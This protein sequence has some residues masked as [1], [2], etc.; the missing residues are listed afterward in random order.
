[1]NSSNVINSLSNKHFVFLVNNY[2]VYGGAERQAFILATYLKSKLNCKVSF[3]SYEPEGIFKNMLLEQNFST[4][5]VPFKHKAKIFHKIKDYI[6]ITCVIRSIKPDVLI[7]YVYES[8]KIVAQIWKYTGASFAFWNQR[9]E[10]RNLYGT[11]LEKKL[12]RSVSAVVSNSYEGQDAL[13][14]VYGLAPDQVQVINNGILP[15]L[16]SENVQDWHAHFG[17]DS[18]RPLIAMIANITKRKDHHTLLEA[19]ALLIQR[20]KQK[21]LP[22]PFLV[23]AGGKEE[24]YDPLRLLAF[25]LKL[26]NH[27]GFTG[28]LKVVQGLIRQSYFCVFSSNLEGC[29]NGVLECMEQGKAVVGTHISGVEQALGTAYTDI[30]LSKPNN[31]LD[32]ADKIMALYEQPQLI[33]EIGKHNAERIRTQFSVEQ[34]ANRHLELILDRIGS[35]S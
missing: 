32:L 13:V 30:C 6:K 34:M 8:N 5:S 3:V 24:M 12:I 28:R 20:V 1:M 17:I 26:C 11:S 2:S 10:G 29:P 18:S 27:V 35:I 4:Y 19:W 21:N 33:Q 16:G 25:D 14:R 9:E 22:L 31:A 7:P 23:L 15:H